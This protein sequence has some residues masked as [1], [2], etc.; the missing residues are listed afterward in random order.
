MTHA[1]TNEDLLISNPFGTTHFLQA[2]TD[3]GIDFI[4]ALQEWE[5]SEDVAH[6]NRVMQITQSNLARFLPMA[7][8]MGA[9]IAHVITDADTGE[10]RVVHWS[11]PLLPPAQ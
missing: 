7:Q 4:A 8:R 6:N 10:S 9:Q 11:R 1:L 2:V 3:R 5:F